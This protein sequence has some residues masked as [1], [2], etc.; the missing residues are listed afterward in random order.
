M[1][2]P[3][4]CQKCNQAIEFS[5]DFCFVECHHYFHGACI[6][7]SQ[8]CPLCPTTTQA[9]ATALTPP[10][11]GSSLVLRLFLGAHHKLDVEALHAMGL[12]FDVAKH[13]E[14]TVAE[15]ISH[16]LTM[17]DLVH[18]LCFSFPQLKEMQLT[19]SLMIRARG[20]FPLDLL[21]DELKQNYR[22]LHEEL[23][24]TVNHLLQQDFSSEEMKKLNATVPVL[25][26]T[27]EWN[28]PLFFAFEKFTLNQ[29]CDDL[30]LTW[31]QLKSLNISSAEWKQLFQKTQGSTNWN[32][33]GLCERFPDLN[34]RDRRS[35]FN[36]E[37]ERMAFLSAQ[38]GVRIK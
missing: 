15:A 23:G 32:L 35:I 10:Q 30:Q 27:K 29:W 16:G 11:S 8:T 14:F 25:I 13:I 36:E 37:N 20:W 7:Y 34:P 6:N 1:Q 21:V 4:I 38:Y 26:E 31:P 3:L 9:T 28:K 19:P 17:N 33:L 22:T 24:L 5:T 12:S 18:G 2:F